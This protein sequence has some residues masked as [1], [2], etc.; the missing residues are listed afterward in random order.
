M[1]AALAGNLCVL[2]GALKRGGRMVYE[3]PITS[4]GSREEPAGA[5]GE[6][7]YGGSLARDLIPFVSVAECFFYGLVRADRPCLNVDESAAKSL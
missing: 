3:S 2:G 1:V 6:L 7:I 4:V 5:F